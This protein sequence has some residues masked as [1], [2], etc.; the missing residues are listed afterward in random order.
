MMIKKTKN[1]KEKSVFVAIVVFVVLLAL[2]FG[3]IVYKEGLLKKEPKYKDD[4][5][6]DNECK[7]LEK[8][9]IK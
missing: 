6:L 4:F 3:T 8:E 9:R 2:I 1:K 7:C 5:F